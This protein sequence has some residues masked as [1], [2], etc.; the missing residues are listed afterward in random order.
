MTN[1]L[2]PDEDIPEGTPE[3]IRN[4]AK[5]DLMSDYSDEFA[6]LLQFFSENFTEN[7]NG[8][9]AVAIPSYNGA[10]AT[11]LENVSSDLAETV[12]SRVNDGE[13]NSSQVA[14]AIANDELVRCTTD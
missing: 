10:N 4:L 1:Q 7:E 9:L 6:D 13:Y 2:V 14:V 8:D 3:K 5:A 11:E 12:N